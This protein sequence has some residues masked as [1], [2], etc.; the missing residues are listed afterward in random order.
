MRRTLLPLASL[1]AVAVLLVAACSD[2][3]SSSSGSG[4]GPAT[5]VDQSQ[6]DALAKKAGLEGE[7]TVKGELEGKPSSGS[8]ATELDDFYFGPTFID[9]AAG[10]TVKVKLH[11]EGK[12]DHT[13]TI[14]SASIDE[15]VDAG[16][17]AEVDVK[18]PASG[19]LA[20]YCRFHKSRGMQGAVIVES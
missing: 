11:N 13:F 14:D 18:V 5:E 16:K 9:A 1:L 15:T 10:S 4:S 17:T 7:V 2:D 20:F 19:S 8:I 12:V 6:I 3:S